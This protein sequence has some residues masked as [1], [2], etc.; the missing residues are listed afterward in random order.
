MR[1][2]PSALYLL[3]LLAAFLTATSAWA[4]RTHN[5]IDEGLKEFAAGEWEDILIDAEGR[6]ARAPGLSPW[7]ELGA[8]VVWDVA[9]APD[10]AL[11]LGTGNRGEILRVTPDGTVETLFDPEEILT[12]AVEVDAEGFIY[13]ATSPSG[14]VYRLRPGDPPVVWF[15]PTETY[16][17]DLRLDAEGRLLVATGGPAV[18]YR[19]PAGYRPGNTV[20]PF[21]TA[22]QT[23]LTTLAPAPEGA[24]YA[25]TGDKGVIYRIADDGTAF[26]LWES[27]DDEIHR[28]EATPDGGLLASTFNE[29]SGGK[30]S[31]SSGN[32][33]NGNGDDEENGEG[34][35][36]VFTVTAF[37]DAEVPVVEDRGGPSRLLRIRP[38]GYV[39]T[40]WRL[41]DANI[42]SFTDAGDQG[43]LIGT[44]DD[45][46]ILRVRG[47]RDWDLFQQA[48]DGGEVA[49]L[50][51]DPANPGGRLVITGNPAVIY[52]LEAEPVAS[53]TYTS[54]VHDLRQVVGAG[55]F[56]VTGPVGDVRMR[57]GNT[58][59]PGDTW[60]P[61]TRVALAADAAIPPLP[62][63][64]Y[65]QYELTLTAESD[66]ENRGVR[67]T[68]L[69]FQLP[70]EAP[71]IT[72]LR[73][74]PA[75]LTLLENQPNTPNV[76]LSKF[77]TS[78]NASDLIEGRDARLLLKNENEPGW[79]A[80]AWTSYDP[81]GDTLE[82]AVDLR[83]ETNGGTWTPLARELADPFHSFPVKGLDEGWY[84]VRVT[85]S[86]RPE[87][88]EDAALTGDLVSEIFLLDHTP[89][90]LTAAN[91]GTV[92]ATDDWSIIKEATVRINGGDP[93]ALRPGDGLYDERI[94]S[95]AVE[96]PADARVVYEVL[97]ENGN[98]A[99]L[100]VP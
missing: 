72:N 60:T 23:H 68:R 84:R 14:R 16:I 98:R 85:A 46:K 55:H 32:G 39:E 90:E 7:V 49:H 100:I 1:R 83:H 78:G 37:S 5:I 12:R 51:P 44:N 31:G 59:E 64:R 19:L 53:A 42:F 45:G 96:A 82:F 18:L 25:G 13:V 93:V 58:K 2:L 26:A 20:E 8:P 47:R 63:A 28:L 77:V 87:N 15:D 4:L 76:P 54:K 70:N 21:F 17:W 79:M 67:R 89:P 81:N 35:D 50:H 97:D 65:W 6:V 71:Q 41:N 52:R 92:T 95:F 38:S 75:R 56:R 29:P 9:T 91:D 10:G 80:V 24:L 73:L 48:P 11:I 69:F 43:V 88:E 33:K 61:W 36:L 99:V 22:P 40:L 94:E 34:S 3:P 57:A 86:D 74:A 30:K 27:G 62:P 66:P